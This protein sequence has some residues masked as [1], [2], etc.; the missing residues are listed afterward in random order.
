M[1]TIIIVTTMMLLIMVKLIST[2]ERTTIEW[3]TTEWII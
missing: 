3:M 1:M 2:G